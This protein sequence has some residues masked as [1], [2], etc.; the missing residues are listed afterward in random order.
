MLI[1]WLLTK[2]FR[3]SF[4]RATR[5]SKMDSQ[6]RLL[7]SRLISVSMTITGLLTAISVV[8]DSFSFGQVI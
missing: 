3:A 7:A 4:E 5:R 1:F 2:A 8:V 6:L